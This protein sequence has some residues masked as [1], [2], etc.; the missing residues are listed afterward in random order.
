MSS[1][2]WDRALCHCVSRAPQFA[3]MWWCHNLEVETKTLSQNVSPDYPVMP[4]HCPEE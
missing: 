2:Y 4:N 1:F 3:T